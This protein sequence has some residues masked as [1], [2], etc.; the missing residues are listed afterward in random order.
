MLVNIISESRPD[1]RQI[2][3]ERLSKTAGVVPYGHKQGYVE[4]FANENQ[5]KMT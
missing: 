3:L 1:L 4:D 2:W 5:A